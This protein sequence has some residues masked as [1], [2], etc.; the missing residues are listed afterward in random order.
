M[1]NEAQARLTRNGIVNSYLAK[2]AAVFATDVAM[3][4]ISAKFVKDTDVAAAA[5][6]EAEIDN[7]GYS[8]EKL[9]AKT[10]ASITAAELCGNCQVKLDISENTIV[11]SSLHA[12][13]TYYST[14]AAALCCSRLMGVYNI[15]LEN[16]T[17]ITSDYLTAAQLES[18]LE[19]INTYKELVG[20]AGMVIGGETVATKLAEST[21]KVTNADLVTM[22]KAALKYKSKNPTFYK[23]LIKSIKIPTISVRHTPVVVTV[24]DAV[25]KELIGGVSVKMTKSKETH[26]TNLEGIMTSNTVSAGNT[27]ATLDKLGYFS[28]LKQ[29]KILRGQI[30]EFTVYL[31]QGTMTAEEEE[32]FAVKLAEAIAAEK[33]ATAAKS[34][35]RK[36]N[37]AAKGEEI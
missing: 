27:M 24:F 23:G 6:I 34:K 30:N 19:E 8:A 3:K 4:T 37:K 7:T 17:L 13:V 2:N 35:S 1:N 28:T 5:S 18:F 20:R 10:T 29:W 31:T 16:L 11:S 9:L 26:V 12:A 33:A 36:A 25:T 21:L 22:Q 32:V 14:V 15:L